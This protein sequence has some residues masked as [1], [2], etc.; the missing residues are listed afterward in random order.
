MRIIF[1]VTGKLRRNK[2]ECV[3][4]LDNSQSF[5]DRSDLRKQEGSFQNLLLYLGVY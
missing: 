2:R 4:A 3:S 1:N 5:F